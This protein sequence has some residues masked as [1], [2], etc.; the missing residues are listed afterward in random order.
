MSAAAMDALRSAIRDAGPSIV[1]FSGGVDSALVLRV[2]R[3]VLG[4]GAVALTAVGPTLPAEEEAEARRFGESLAVQH[5]FV[6]S[7]ELENPDYARNPTDRCYFCKTELYALCH[8]ERERLGLRSILDG[9]NRDDLGD[10]RPGLTAAH[11]NGIRHPLIEAG[12]GKS[13]VR[14]LCRELGIELW[15]KPSFACLGSRFPYGTTITLDR[16]NRLER[17]ERVL[18][19]L[20]FRGFRVRFHDAIARIEV[21]VADLPKLVDPAVRSRIVAGIKAEG[22]DFV[23]V[24]LE[25]YRTGSLNAGLARLESRAAN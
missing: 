6:A 19:E 8:A 25:G 3:D 20:G 22:F 23:T 10:H 15:D 16:L 13:V 24:D 2:A 4:D 12:L 17:C 21:N 11:E 14:D 18:R 7:H 1:A 5:V 9:V